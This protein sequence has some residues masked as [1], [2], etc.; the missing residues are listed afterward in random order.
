LCD[1]AGAK[2]VHP[3]IL[4]LNQVAAEHA[5][6]VDA[7]RW[8][9]EL[10]QLAA[11]DSLNPYLSGLACALVLEMGRISEEELAREVSRRLSPG[12][13]AE[14]GAGWFE[15]LVGYNRMA[16]FSRLALWRQL[17][18]YIVSLDEEGFRQ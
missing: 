12:V 1:R 11:L 9:K 4:G 10:D 15:G 16:I 2:E 18:A 7:D 17:D 13:D 14:L 8:H 5:Q 6:D 3:A